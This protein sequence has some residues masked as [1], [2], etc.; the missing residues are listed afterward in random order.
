M[1]RWTATA[2][3]TRD[4]ELVMTSAGSEICLMRVA[5]K[6]AGRD[7]EAGY[8]EVKAFGP[9]AGACAKYLSTGREVAI[10][11]RLGFEEFETKAGQYASRVYVIADQV[12]FLASPRRRGDQPDAHGQPAEPVSVPDHKETAL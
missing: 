7:G 1:N 2:H 5:V 12:E 11:G 10:E 6:R 9:Q 3:L 8:F 4:P